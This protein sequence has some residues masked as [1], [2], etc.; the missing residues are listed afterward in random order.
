MFVADLSKRLRNRTGGL[1]FPFSAASWRA[2]I[3]ARTLEELDIWA[4]LEGG[5][6]RRKWSRKM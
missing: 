6:T 3:N 5:P 4:G 1:E 2:E